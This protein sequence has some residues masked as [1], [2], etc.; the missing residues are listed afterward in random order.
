MINNYNNNYM[1][2]KIFIIDYNKEY[3][4]SVPQKYL[5]LIE[6]KFFS[7]EWISP[8]LEKKIVLAILWNGLKMK[9]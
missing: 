7:E 8:Y 1:N 9:K 2:L 6:H 5:V 3:I 4:S